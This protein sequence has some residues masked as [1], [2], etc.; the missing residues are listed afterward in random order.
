MLNKAEGNGLTPGG[1][2]LVYARGERTDLEGN[3]IGTCFQIQYP[4]ENRSAVEII[5][6]KRQFLVSNRYLLYHDPVPG[7]VGPNGVN[8]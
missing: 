4:L 3:G 5:N 8:D 7:R 2:Q 1:P 6:G